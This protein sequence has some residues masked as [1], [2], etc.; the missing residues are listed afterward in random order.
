MSAVVDR[1]IDQADPFASLSAADF[2]TLAS[3]PERESATPADAPAPSTD[4]TAATPATRGRDEQGRFAGKAEP[5]EATTDDTPNDAPAPTEAATTT[6]EPVAPVVDWEAEARK[7]QRDLAA[8]RGQVDNAA[9][10]AAERARQEVAQQTAAQA[11]QTARDA[12][13]AQLNQMLVS[14][15]LSQDQAVAAYQRNQ[16][17]W[18]QEDQQA[19]QSQLMQRETGVKLT[20][21]ETAGSQA[22]VALYHQG[23]ARMAEDFNLPVDEVRAVW[24]DEG[25]RQRFQRAVWQSKMADEFPG[26]P[27]NK[28]AA[29][30]YLASKAQDFQQR[31]TLHDTYQTQ[32]KAKDAE[33]ERLRVL[34]NRD[35]AGEGVPAPQSVRR[36]ARNAPA[37]PDEHA[38]RVLTDHISEFARAFGL[39]N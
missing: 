24:N 22:L 30:D 28:S 25:E 16:Q 36:A 13:T 14:G 23:A 4:E 6:P 32:L 27:F 2:A 38:E 33:I 21:V 7:L 26:L 8:Q 17:Q 37:T 34:V 10:Q 29:E 39:Q 20:T 1:P 15:E 18:A 9:K 35:E 5:V 12:I 3:E 11:Q 19:A 31:R